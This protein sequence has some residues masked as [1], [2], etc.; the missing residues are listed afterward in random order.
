MPLHGQFLIPEDR[1]ESG[2][3]YAEWD[4]FTEASFSPNFPDVAADENA[5]I[6]S[7]TG[8]AFITSGGNLYSFQA[9]VNLQLDD[10]TDLTVRSVFVQMATLGSGLDREGA[11]LLVED[12]KGGVRVISPTQTFVTS[13]EELTGERGGVETTYGL[14]WDLRGTPLTGSYTILLNALSS[15]LSIDRISLDLSENYREVGKP[16]PLSVR[17][18]DDEVV[19]SWFGTRKLQ[20]SSSGDG[21]WTDVPGSEEVNE[22]IF[23]KAG[24]VRLFRLRQLTATERQVRDRVIFYQFSNYPR[25]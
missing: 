15:S 10:T 6:T 5:S 21:E 4:R 19:V 3:A 17:V 20:T 22:M 9:P 8:S 23:P 1:G 25:L 11:R 2:T 16:K 18:D 24:G 12:G 13:E 7:T 14:H